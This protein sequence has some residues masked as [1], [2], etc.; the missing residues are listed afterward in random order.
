MGGGRETLREGKYKEAF[1]GIGRVQKAWKHLGRIGRR[2]H[3]K[4][5]FRI[6]DQEKIGTDISRTFGKGSSSRRAR[7]FGEKMGIITLKVYLQVS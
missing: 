6:K 2:T 3:L 7:R 5:L 4:F 1:K